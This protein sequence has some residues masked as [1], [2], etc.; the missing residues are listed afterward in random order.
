LADPGHA[1]VEREEFEVSASRAASDHDVLVTAG[2]YARL[3]DELETLRTVRRAEL[4]EQF[5]AVRQDADPDNPVLFDVL[6]EQAKLEERISVLEALVAAARVVDPTAD[7]SAGIGSR[8]R[9]R[10]GEGG[11]LADYELVTPVESDAGNARV[12]IGAP[13]GAALLGGRPGD[14]VVVETPRG[15]ELLEIVGVQP[16][17]KTTRKAA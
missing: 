1:S 13:V 6:E 2:G 9:V 7:G 17:S 5:R 11:E 12:S 8:V 10:H 14:T 4:A 15:A 3:R 16:A